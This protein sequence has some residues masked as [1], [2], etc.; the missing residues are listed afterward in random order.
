MA[1][2][3]DVRRIALSLPGAV[4]AEGKFGFAV[5]DKTKLRPFIWPWHERKDPKKARV[6]NPGVIVLRVASLTDKEMLLASDSEKFFTE[7][8]YD[9]YRAVLVRL[10]AIGARELREVIAASWRC[11][12]PRALVARFDAR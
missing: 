3:A 9:G 10:E 5:K 2:Q 12:A 4:E 8:H 6:P 11:R 1:S 7:P